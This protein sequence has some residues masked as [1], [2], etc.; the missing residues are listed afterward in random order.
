MFEKDI[1]ITL[2]KW[3]NKHPQ[4]KLVFR[5]V[6][7]LERRLR[8]SQTDQVSVDLLER[9]QDELN[10]GG[11]SRGDILIALRD[12]E[13]RQWDREVKGISVSELSR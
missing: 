2:Q 8:K 9:A 7:E 10:K 5:S 11:F 3:L 1:G 4:A 13:Q 6:H 12:L